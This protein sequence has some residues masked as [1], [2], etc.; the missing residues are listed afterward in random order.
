MMSLSVYS[1]VTMLVSL[2]LETGVRK[3]HKDRPALEAAWQPTV[4]MHHATL[5]RIHI[6]W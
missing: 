4:V 1:L 5:L 2:E 3:S 6:F